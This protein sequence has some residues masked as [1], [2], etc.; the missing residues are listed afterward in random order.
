MV[1]TIWRAKR[2]PLSEWATLQEQFG[3]FQIATGAPENL[4]MF[5]KDIPGSADSMIY[6]IGPGIGTIEALSPGGWED[7]NAPSG[8]GVALLVGSG[9]PWTFYGIDKPI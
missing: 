4:A 6:I 8:K 7:T 2:L 5:A 3:K 1:N 9:D